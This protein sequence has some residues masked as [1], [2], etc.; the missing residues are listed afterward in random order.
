MPFLRNSVP[1]F[2]IA[3]KKELDLVKEK[4]AA[5][6]ATALSFKMQERLGHMANNIIS[7]GNSIWRQPCP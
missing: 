6:M 4:A 7:G 5:N 1:I 2:V 3:V